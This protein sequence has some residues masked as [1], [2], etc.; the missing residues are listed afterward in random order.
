MNDEIAAMTVR[1]PGEMAAELGAVAR[2][3]G[4]SVSQATRDAID[5]H[6]ATRRA[7]QAFQERLKDRLNEDRRVLERLTA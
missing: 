3:D 7:D 1:L 6:I 5:S 4:I 2:T